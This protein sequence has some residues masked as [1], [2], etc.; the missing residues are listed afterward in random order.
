MALEMEAKPPQ[1]RSCVDFL[2]V[3]NTGLLALTE[4]L[5]KRLQS[6]LRSMLPTG[7]N[8]ID[9]KATLVPLANSLSEI[10]EGLI[11]VEARL[12]S[13]LNRLEI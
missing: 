5:E 2:Y 4:E 3:K 8:A 10:T 13:I 1:V 9:E 12:T 6:V 11:T 7:A